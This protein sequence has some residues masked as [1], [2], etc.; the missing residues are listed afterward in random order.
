MTW[1]PE[2]RHAWRRLKLLWAEL[3]V[4]STAKGDHSLCYLDR[5]EEAA[6]AIEEFRELYY[7]ARRT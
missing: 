2:T 3:L 7:P 1:W 6:T 5:L 4:V